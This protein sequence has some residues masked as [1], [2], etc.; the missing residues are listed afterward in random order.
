MTRIVNSLL[1]VGF[2]MVVWQACQKTP[3]QKKEDILT[4]AANDQSLSVFNNQLAGPVEASATCAGPYTVILEGVINNNNGTWTWTWSV[5]NPNPGNG[6][7]GTVQNLSHWAISLGQC[8]TIQHVISG[9][10]SANAQTWTSFTPAWAPDPSLNNPNS[11]GCSITNPVLKFDFGTTG[12]AKSYYRLTVNQNFQVDPAVTAWY[13]SGGNTG[14][15]SFCFAGFGCVAPNE[16]C[17]FSQGYWFAKP[18]LV[19]PDVNAAAGNVT[20]GGHHYTQAEGKAIWNANNAGG[21]ADTKKGFLQVAAIKLS[22]SSVLPAATVWA[23]VTIVENWL[24]T[25]P[26]LTTSNLRNYSNSAAAAAAG[27]IGEWIN[28]HHCD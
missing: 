9:A 7:N 15:G 28:Y 8:A 26:K 2:S 11:N 18:G 5:A 27:R 14:C 24:S 4:P 3:D 17:S 16:G 25:L 19:W 20:I 23:D 13:K 21:I 1:L 6:T 10:Y 22:G 12:T